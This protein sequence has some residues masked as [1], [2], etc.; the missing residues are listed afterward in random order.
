MENEELQLKYTL[1]YLDDLKIS[2]EYVFHLLKI[3]KLSIDSN[4]EI[5][6]TNKYYKLPALPHL[7][8]FREDPIILKFISPRLKSITDDTV[9]LTEELE[10]LWS[11][12]GL[13]ED[14]AYNIVKL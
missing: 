1:D 8:N 4:T 9:A 5:A 14:R 2:S 6:E 13:K 10:T 11:S 3:I 12:K 7:N